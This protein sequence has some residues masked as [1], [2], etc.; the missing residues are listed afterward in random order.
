ME[1]GRDAPKP[2]NQATGSDQEQ[3]RR[4]KAELTALGGVLVFLTGILIGNS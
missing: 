1:R 4:W 3:A 2:G